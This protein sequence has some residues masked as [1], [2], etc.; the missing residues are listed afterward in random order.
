MMMR[1]TA[2]RRYWRSRSSSVGMKSS[3]LSLA[4]GVAD[5]RGA[6]L[7]LGWLPGPGSCRRGLWFIGA[8]AAGHDSDVSAG[9]GSFEEYVLQR[10]GAQDASIEVGED[11]GEIGGAEACRDGGECGGG[12]TVLDRGEE[13]AAVAEQDAD[14]AEDDGDVLGHDV[15]GLILGRIGRRGWTGCVGYVAF[16]V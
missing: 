13:M 7:E 12:G 8:I 11:G 3:G 10:G 5:A 16:H 9:L 1:P 15:A 4:G 14:G 2:R 6:G